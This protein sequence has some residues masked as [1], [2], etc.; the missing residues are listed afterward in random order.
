MAAYGDIHK[1]A[2][3]VKMINKWWERKLKSH[4]KRF[5]LIDTQNST[6][7]FIVLY[8]LQPI[9]RPEYVIPKCNKLS[10]LSK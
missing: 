6:G 2:V 4:E 7:V 5:S 1:F 3:K 10:N 9:V 8:C